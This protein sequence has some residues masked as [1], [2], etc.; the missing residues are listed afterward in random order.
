M[1]GGV[2]AFPGDAGQPTIH[3]RWLANELGE[4]RKKYLQI[5]YF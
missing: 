2:A 4:C 5:S 1:L 3:L